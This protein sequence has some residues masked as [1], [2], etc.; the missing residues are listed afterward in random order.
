MAQD[1]SKARVG[2]G[3]VVAEQIS[4]WH[5]L[6]QEFGIMAKV[7]FVLQGFRKDRFGCPTCF[8]SL[9]D[10][11]CRPTPYPRKR[12]VGAYVARGGEVVTIFRVE[13]LIFLMLQPYN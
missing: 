7:R 10:P 1:T 11:Y 9:Q 12:E 8:V 2:Q 3:E 6:P 4:P 13:S 5:L